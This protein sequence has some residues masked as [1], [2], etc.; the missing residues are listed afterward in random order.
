MPNHYLEKNIFK[1]KRREGNI[2]SL[3]IWKK[4]DVEQFIKFMYTNS[5]IYLDR[6]YERAKTTIEDIQRL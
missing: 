5:T 2:Y 3:K 6:K 4:E 1:E